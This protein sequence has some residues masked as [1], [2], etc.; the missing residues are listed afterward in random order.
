MRLLEQEGCTI[1][2][3]WAYKGMRVIWLENSYLRIGILPDR[4]SDIFEFR[5]KPLD[6][7]LLLN[8]PGRLRNLNT[9]FSQMRDTKSQFEDHYYGGWQEI[10]P[11]GPALTYRRA[12]LGQH[13]EVSLI[14]WK[15]SILN[16][17][18]NEVSVR[19]TGT[20][21]RF[22]ISIEKTISLKRGDNNITISEKLTN[23]SNTDLDLMWGQHIALGTSFVEDELEIE[24]NA[25]QMISEPGMPDK[26]KFKP[27]IQTE[28]PRAIALNGS[29]VDASIFSSRGKEV[30]SELSYLNEFRDTATAKGTYSVINKAQKISFNVS[31]DADIFKCLWMWQERE[32]MQ[33]F[34]WWGN[35]YTLALE[36][37]TSKWTNDPEGAINRGEWLK[38][39]EGQE[40]ST[41][42][43]AGITEIQ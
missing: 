25:T 24:T 30:Y 27:G 21:V 14:P 5:Y 36:P 33:G 9:D 41:S 17:S 37:W 16:T 6:I 43:S 13:G 7:N 39:A 19:L 29:K 10:L 2:D 4:G 15:Y 38:L 11:N 3:E 18:E 26:R 32:A 23:Q 12:S 31:W 1:T 40:I 8:L 42:I 35:C 22:P 34:P 20:P 28:W